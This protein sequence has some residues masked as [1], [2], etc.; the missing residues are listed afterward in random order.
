MFDAEAIM[1]D[2]DELLDEALNLKHK[3]VDDHHYIFTACVVVQKIATLEINSQKKSKI[4]LIF[5]LTCLC[6][7]HFKT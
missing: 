6:Q 1:I 4:S 5:H 3:K 2:V 7:E